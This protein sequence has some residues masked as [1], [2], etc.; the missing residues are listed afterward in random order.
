MT[1]RRAA[2]LDRDGVLNRA[3]VR[4]GRPYAPRHLAEFEIL[5]EAAGAVARLTAAGLLTIVVTNQPDVARGL[6][7][8]ATLDEM[9]RRLRDAMR[10]DDIRICIGQDGCACYKPNPGML[11]A[12]ARAWD[13]DL[14]GSVMIGDRWRDVGAGRAAG[15]R[16]VFV[17]R[18]YAERL[19]D[20]PDFTVGDIAEAAALVVAGLPARGS[21]S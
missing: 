3:I 14:Q 12:A 10:L 21:A 5:P 4:N 1:T 7:T 6:V 17:D 18:G 19:I 15:C 16:T 20:R 9:H 8:H 13:I 11:L 2:F